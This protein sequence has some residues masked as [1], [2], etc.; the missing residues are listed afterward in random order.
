MQVT[1]FHNY[2]IDVLKRNNLIRKACVTY[3][4][5]AFT[6]HANINCTCTMSPITAAS[7]LYPLFTWETI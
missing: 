5:V 7:A 3:N 4:L 2:Q 1:I 6:V